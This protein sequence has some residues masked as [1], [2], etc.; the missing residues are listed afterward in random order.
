MRNLNDFI[1]SPNIKTTNECYTCADQEYS[2]GLEP[3]TIDTVSMDGEALP[4][5]QVEV[6]KNVEIQATGRSYEFGTPPEIKIGTVEYKIQ[7]FV[8]NIVKKLNDKSINLSFQNV[9][10]LVKEQRYLVVRIYGGLNGK[11]KWTEYM[12]IIPKVFNEIEKEYHCWLVQLL[13][14][15]CDD[16]FTL[17]IGIRWKESHEKK[18]DK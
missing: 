17:E 4:S 16:A 6:P 14:D 5:T 7:E 9:I 12:Q 11:G 15:C 3:V 13:N 18:A 8:Y 1:Y 2:L 10:E